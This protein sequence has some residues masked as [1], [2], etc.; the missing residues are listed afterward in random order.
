[1]PNFKP[2][3]GEHPVTARRRINQNRSESKFGLPRNQR[4]SLRPGPGQKPGFGPR[5][6]M[7]PRPRPGIGNQGVMGGPRPGAGMR[8]RPGVRRPGSGGSRRM[9]TP[10]IGRVLTG[11]NRRGY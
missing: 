9:G 11:R 2:Y 10:S 1:M 7:P 3:P 5:P 4:S 8:N 6:G